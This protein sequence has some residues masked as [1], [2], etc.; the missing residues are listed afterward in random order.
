MRV[1][2]DAGIREKYGIFRAGNI[3]LGFGNIQDAAPKERGNPDGRED[4]IIGAE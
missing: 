2:L 4:P 3:R 1:K